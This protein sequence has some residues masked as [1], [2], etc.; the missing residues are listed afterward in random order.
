M[1]SSCHGGRAARPLM[2]KLSANNTLTCQQAECAASLLACQARACFHNLERA[3]LLAQEAEEAAS[4]LQQV[5]VQHPG[6]GVQVVYGITLHGSHGKRQVDVGSGAHAAM[7]QAPALE[8]S[9][10]QLSIELQLL[11]RQLHGRHRS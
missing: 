1:G 4:G 8:S 3:L 9:I 10:L 5:I 2:Q 11:C 7:L 6:P